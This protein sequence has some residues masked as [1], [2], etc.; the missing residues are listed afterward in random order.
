MYLIN[1][2]AILKYIYIYFMNELFYFYFEFIIIRIIKFV[3]KLYY[4]VI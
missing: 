4:F 2:I 3:N 1:K